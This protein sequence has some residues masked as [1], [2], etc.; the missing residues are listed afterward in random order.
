MK[1]LL[2]RAAYSR[3]NGNDMHYFFNLQCAADNNNNDDN[4]N[5]YY[6][7]HYN[8]NNDVIDIMMI[9]MTIIPVTYKTTFFPYN[10]D[11]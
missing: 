8:N 7:Y 11:T 10:D 2:V 6:Y 5:S 3:M 1:G 9:L 4:N